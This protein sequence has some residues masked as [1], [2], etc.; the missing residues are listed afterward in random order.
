[1]GQIMK[2]FSKI[3]VISYCLLAIGLASSCSDANEYENAIT[4]NPSWADAS[5]PE[6][7]ANTKY[8][9]GTGIKTNAYGDEVQ[10]FV[11][12]LD[13]VSSDSV[14]VKMSQGVTEGEWSDESNNE[15]IP[16]YEYTYSDAT[17]RLEIM[18]RNIDDNGK[19]SKKVI[20]IGTAITGQHNIITI[21]H[22]GDTPA[23]T[24]LVKQ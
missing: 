22:Y 24:Y 1:M 17:G 14:T 10:G 8:V 7:L 12:S 11:E 9:R 23:Q 5:Y 2:L 18:K 20:F 15:R 21:V 6:S 3:T 19:V 16:H 13:F 4:D